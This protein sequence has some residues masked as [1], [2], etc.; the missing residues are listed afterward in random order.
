MK[1]ANPQNARHLEHNDGQDRCI[2]RKGIVP[3][4]SNDGVALHPGMTSLQKA[5][6]GIGGLGHAT[7]VIDGG[8][9]VA[10]S[11]A[12]APTQ[13]AYGSLPNTKAGKAV[14]VNPGMRGSTAPRNTDLG[15]AILRQAFSVT[16]SATCAA[17]GRNTDGSRK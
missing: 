1:I 6:A 11:A 8:Q 13:H 10:T 7:A 16:D 15:E 12:A 14:A 2:A 4:R 17:H 3:K 5:G 9:I